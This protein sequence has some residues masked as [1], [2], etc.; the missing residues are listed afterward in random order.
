MGRPASNKKGY[1]I[2]KRSRLNK[3]NA[4]RRCCSY[5]PIHSVHIHDANLQST[6][7]DLDFSCDRTIEFMES[8]D[9]RNI[10]SVEIAEQSIYFDRLLK[11]HKGSGNIR[12]PE[13]LKIGFSSI[14]KYIREGVPV[15][16]P[17]NVYHTFVAADFLLL[18]KLK[19]QC[20]NLFKEMATIDLS[21]AINIWL[22]YKSFYWPEL[23]SMA[24]Q[25]ILENFEDLWQTPEFKTLDVNHLCQIL[26]EDTLNC[27]HETNVFYAVI[28]WISEDLVRRIQYSLELLL[29][30]RLG[31]LTTNELNDIKKHDLTQI[32]PEYLDLLNQWPKCLAT[33]NNRIIKAYGQRFVTPRLPHQIAMVFGGWRDGEGPVAAVQV[34]NPVVK[35]WTLWTKNS[36]Q[37]LI[38]TNQQLHLFQ[39]LLTFTINNSQTNKLQDAVDT[40]S[41]I[42]NF[43]SSL[44]PDGINCE[45]NPSELI[46][47]NKKIMSTTHDNLIGEIPKRV[48]AG[49]VLI[50]TRVYVIGGFDGYRALKSTL[51]YD[52]QVESGWYEASCMYENRYYVSVA[53]ANGQIYAIGGHNGEHGGRLDS[54]ERYIVDEN[55]WQT[56]SSMNYVRSDGS[57]GELHGKIYVIGGFDG[58]YYHDSVEYYEPMTD[59]WTLVSRMNSPRSGVSLIQHNDYLYAIGGN[60]G[61]DRLKSIERYDP[62]ENK[63]EIIGEMS[64]SRSNLS[65]TVIDNEIYILGGWSGEPASGISDQV[66][67]YNV[68]SCECRIVQ[69]L[70]YPVSASCACTLKGCD[71]VKKYINP[72]S[73]VSSHCLDN[74]NLVYKGEEGKDRDD[75][76]RK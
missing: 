58:R 55:L 24:Y 40:F 34:Y 14:I 17:D 75:D 54:A 35:E 7:D 69:S 30:I 37:F 72:L 32:I 8:G 26:H 25:A 74:F 57:A 49:C 31:M 27:K 73:T 39:N 18:P 67:C 19:Q 56:I 43:R 71:L 9:T 10:I 68:I 52:F 22:N 1:K 51:C 70:I 61:K 45:G 65:T 48:Y 63:W 20:V 33:T 12:L 23:S 16:N 50:G 28:Q 15:I 64:R 76:D 2:G 5:T 66:E 4:F 42:N 36:Q 60:N 29:C 53:Y 47:D 3:L 6:D 41:W 11:Y 59:Q 13:F 38:P 21:T 62:K 44:P 46:V